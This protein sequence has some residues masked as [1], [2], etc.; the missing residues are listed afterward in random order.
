MSNLLNVNL[1][2][3]LLAGVG[4][5]AV[6]FLW[7]S[8]FLFEKSWLKEMGWTAES[9]KEKKK[10]M[11][12]GKVFGMTFAGSLVTA[13]ALAVLMQ[14]MNLGLAG[15]LKLAVLLWAGF[16]AT[17]KLNDVLFEAKSKKLFAIDAGHLLAAMLV[18][19][20]ILSLI[21]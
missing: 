4:S 7:F 9:M 5:M 13:A 10:D 18:M 6:G 17:V 16:M 3:V 12:M 8:P 14:R 20:I 19:S 15:G 2:R 11:Q 1:L 21:R